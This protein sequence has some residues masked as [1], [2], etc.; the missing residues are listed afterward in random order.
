MVAS[1]LWEAVSQNPRE[2]QFQNWY[3]DITDWGG[4]TS[5]IRVASAEVVDCI[6]TY[7]SERIF[8]SIGLATEYIPDI[9]NTDSL[10]GYAAIRASSSYGIFLTAVRLIGVSLEDNGIKQLEKL[11]AWC[12][13]RLDE[14]RRLLLPLDYSRVT[15]IE[16]EVV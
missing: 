13:F 16:S 15:P 10:M 12:S 14:G 5:P 4:K 3:F 7:T 9:R 6:G 2:L 11:T 1:N 8:Y